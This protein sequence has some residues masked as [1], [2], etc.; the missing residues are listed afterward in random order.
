MK[1]FDNLINSFYIII[2]PLIVAISMDLTPYSK[3]IES[4]WQQLNQ[5]K[6]TTQSNIWTENAFVILR[7][8]PWQSPLWQQ[9][10]EDQYKQNDF[11]G[12]IYSFK[13]VEILQ[14]LSAKQKIMLGNAL[15]NTNQLEDA[16][17]TWQGILEVS[18]IKED[19]FQ[20]LVQIQQSANDWYG[21]YLTLLKWQ[22]LF[23]ESTE[24]V[25]PLLLSQVIFDP[26]AAQK[27]LLSIKNG[28]L[29]TISGDLEL[30]LE[31]ENPVY[32]LIL[33]GNIFSKINQWNYAVV[34][35]ANAT[36]LD[37][38]YA[39]GWAFYGNALTNTGENGYFALEKALT[40]SPQSKIARA[41]LASYWRS[42]NDIVKSLEIYQSLTDEE[43]DQ[44]V[45][46]QELGNTYIS[47]GNLDKALQAFINAVEVDPSNAYNWITLA[48]FCGDFRIEIQAI[49][50]PAARQ[51]L[52]ID[53]Q[54]WEANDVIGWLFL[55]L[56]DYTSA[57]RFLTLAY[58]IAPESDIVNLHLGQLFVLQDKKELA[59]YFLNRSIEFSESKEIIRLARN[60]LSP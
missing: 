42:Q 8:Q 6:N 14:P 31:N 39:E 3:S 44:P 35:Y 33:A 40:L 27:T 55:L 24:M 48:R 20:E 25:T 23:P 12:S 26:S 60:F 34:A 22:Q 5:N 28:K 58:E 56:D 16:Y 52:I 46:Q 51:A 50:L 11:L 21:A 1:K 15:W 54:N 49:G 32:Q 57:E 4:F 17:S 59:A 19:D 13:Q 18:D 47:S 36:R 29:Q 2:L 45:W 37:P 41:Y 30:I 9:L 43:P 7:H 38:E 10:A 53:D